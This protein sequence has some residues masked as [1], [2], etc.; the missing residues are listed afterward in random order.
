MWDVMCFD[1]RSDTRGHL[2]VENCK[3]VLETVSSGGLF[4]D[5][6]LQT[7]V[8]VDHVS[9]LETTETFDERL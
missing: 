6:A 4:H 1:T 8:S 3:P 7:A 5:P 2:I 9:N